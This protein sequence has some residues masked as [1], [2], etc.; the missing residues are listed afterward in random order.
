M[1]NSDF[2]FVEMLQK[3]V[4]FRHCINEMFHFRHKIGESQQFLQYVSFNSVY[5]GHSSMVIWH[6]FQIG[7]CLFSN[8]I[9]ETVMH[10]INYAYLLSWDTLY[11]T[12][13]YRYPTNK[14]IQSLLYV[15]ICIKL[16]QNN[17]CARMHNKERMID[18]GQCNVQ[19]ILINDSNICNIIL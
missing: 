8:E 16:Y 7:Q 14:Y 13:I 10:V 12:I 3:H 19:Y 1:Y 15:M 6:V 18:K 4:L 2:K 17:N 5:L 11:V 9:I